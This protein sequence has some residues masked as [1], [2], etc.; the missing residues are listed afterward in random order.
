[1]TGI[2][3]S[4]N[5][6]RTVSLWVGVTLWA[7]VA[8]AQPAP[9]FSGTWEP[10]SS[11]DLGPGVVQTV[12]H[13][14]TTLTLG[15]ASSGGG[16]RFVYKT[17]GS[18]NHSTLEIHGLIESVATVSIKGD[19]MTIA[20]VDKYPDGRVRENTQ[21]WSLD[22]TG[23]LVIASTDGLRGETPVTRTVVYRKRVISKP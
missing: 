15:H 20:R 9:N 19:A 7:S 4:R 3:A 8:S 16:H 14:N 1:M 13:T 21:L 18:A 12:T 22:P 11:P 6:T 5:R 23:N 2:P 10:I 17:D